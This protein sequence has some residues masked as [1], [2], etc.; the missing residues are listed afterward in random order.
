MVKFF[1]DNPTNATRAVQ[2]WQILVAK[3]SNRQTITYGELADILEWG[4]AGVLGRPLG[5]IMYYCQQNGLPPLTVIVVGKAKGSPGD[6]LDVLPSEQ[7]SAR[8]KVFKHNWF[9]I[10]PPDAEELK[11]A[12]LAGRRE[13]NE[14]ENS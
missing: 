5:H 7:N 14:S 2:I 10:I 9:D 11:K 1:H 13:R 12:R 6:G 3:A 4:G 8:E